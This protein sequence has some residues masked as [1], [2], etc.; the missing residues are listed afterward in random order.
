MLGALEVERDGGLLPLGGPRQRAVLAAL[1]LERD[2]VVPS[3]RLIDLMWSNPP[4]TADGVL[5]NYVSRLRALLEGPKHPAGWSVILTDGHGYRL[6]ADPGTVDAC[7]FEHRLREGRRRFLDADDEG[8]IE[9]LE[10]ALALWRG[11]V[12]PE[13]AEESFVIAEARRLEQLRLTAAE[14]LVDAQLALGRVAAALERL[15][16]LVITYPLNESI[17]RQHMLALCRAGR[18][19]EALASFEALRRS[20]A[21]EIGIDPGRAITDVHRQILRREVEIADEPAIH[22]GL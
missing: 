15:E 10:A 13:F 11:P 14:D 21:D 1:L 5:Q 16:P 7:T 22:A 8:A 20:L 6:R 17:R 4:S 2:R 9:D 12:L 3:A 19:T 18:Q